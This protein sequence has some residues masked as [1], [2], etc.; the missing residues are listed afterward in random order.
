VF[1]RRGALGGG[2]VLAA[3]GADFVLGAPASAVKAPSV[4]VTSSMGPTF[5]DSRLRETRVLWQAR[6][7]RRLVALTFDDGPQPDYTE[8]VIEVLRRYRVRATFNLVGRRIVAHPDL[9]G[10]ELA[11][12]HEL[13]NHT[14]RHANLPLESPARVREELQRTHDLIERLTGRPPRTLRPP[15]GNLSGD[16]LKAAAELGYDVVGWSVKFHEDLF[17]AA[18]N[19]AYVAAHLAPGSVILAH[20]T[21]NRSRLQ[22]LLALPALIEAARRQDYEF[23]TV[24]ELLS[25]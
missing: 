5:P 3:A 25:A 21:G 1:L 18:G 12:R 19:A 8:G 24:S 22:D 10:R 23:V 9:V 13:G 4:A 7:D 16:A 15:Y 11:D 2:A 17:D 6:T 20:D 14:W